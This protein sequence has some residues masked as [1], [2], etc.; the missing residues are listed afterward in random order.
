VRA[1][2]IAVADMLMGARVPR[3]AGRQ[4]G[5]GLEIEWKA[6]AEAPCPG[7]GTPSGSVKQRPRGRVKDAP[8]F[9]RPVVLW[10]R[11][12]RVRCVT[13]GCVRKSFTEIGGDPAS[14]SDF[15]AAAGAG[16]SVDPDP[17]GEGGGSGRGVNKRT[18]YCCLPGEHTE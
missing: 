6:R 3:V 1:E 17:P 18:V 11:K 13:P 8:S 9:G 7:C 4:V 14:G 15:G 5:G 10:W 16:V 12:R 2:G